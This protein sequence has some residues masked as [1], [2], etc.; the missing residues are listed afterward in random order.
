[1]FSVAM[2]MQQWVSFTLLP[3]YKIF[4]LLTLYGTENSLK[5]FSVAME[6][7]QWVSFAL[8]PNYK[9][10]PTAL[11]NINILSSSHKVPRLFVRF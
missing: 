9:I 2:E 7:Q 3:N 1:V 4:L 6:M 10:F 8:L 11:N 5:V